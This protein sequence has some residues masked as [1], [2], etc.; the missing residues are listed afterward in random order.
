ML[1][2]TECTWLQ[3]VACFEL[4]SNNKMVERIL[5]LPTW[6]LILV[7]LSLQAKS[8]GHIGNTS[9]WWVHSQDQ[10]ACLLNCPAALPS[11][12]PI[13]VDNAQQASSSG[14]IWMLIFLLCLSCVINNSVQ[15]CYRSLG[16]FFPHNSYLRKHGFIRQVPKW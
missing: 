9:N 8:Y 15:R 4:S 7:F 5:P 12:L 2:A 6:N 1:N 10:S 11:L 16:T 3:Y 13:I 14:R